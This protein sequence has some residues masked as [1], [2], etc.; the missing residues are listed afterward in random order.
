M[1]DTGYKL[2][3]L[4]N[5]IEDLFI[6]LSFSV[7]LFGDMYNVH[8][9]GIFP[10]SYVKGITLATPTLHEIISDLIDYFNPETTQY[11]KRWQYFKIL[12]IIN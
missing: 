10:P 6:P 5:H 2:F 7:T 1:K 3:N 9:P 11:P 8:I 12:I 4:K